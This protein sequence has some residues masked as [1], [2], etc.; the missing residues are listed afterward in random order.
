MV[1]DDRGRMKSSTDT[2]N[3]N[4]NAEGVWVALQYAE[5]GDRCGVKE[6]FA[7]RGKA[8]NARIGGG[9]ILGG[10]GRK[11]A[12]GGESLTFRREGGGGGIWD[13]LLGDAEKRVRMKFSR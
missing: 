2:K 3:E 13:F 12:Y 6:V 11:N 9:V 1:E 4:S 8:S 10:R 7:P 5:E